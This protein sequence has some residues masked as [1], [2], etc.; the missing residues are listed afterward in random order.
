[1]S[2]QFIFNGLR[3]LECDQHNHSLNYRNFG[4]KLN[5][6]FQKIAG[7][8]LMGV[9]RSCLNSVDKVNSQCT[10]YIWYHAK[11]FSDFGFVARS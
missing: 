3:I 5:A 8:D 10:L 4:K 7:H 6:I 1:M 2:A 9:T 11:N